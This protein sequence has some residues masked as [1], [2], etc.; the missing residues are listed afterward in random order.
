MRFG[1]LGSFDLM[2]LQSQLKTSWII[3]V[4]FSVLQSQE[5]ILIL[6]ARISL[7]RIS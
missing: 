5:V 7:A 1:N 2:V 4:L 6:P 3:A